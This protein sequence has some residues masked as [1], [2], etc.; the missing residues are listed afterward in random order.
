MSSDDETT[1]T[2]AAATDAFLYFQDADGLVHTSRLDALCHAL[3][4]SAP[5]ASDWSRMHVQRQSADARTGRITLDEF[6]SIIQYTETYGINDSSDDSDKEE[7]AMTPQSILDTV[8]RIASRDVSSE[9]IEQLVSDTATVSS[10]LGEYP[11]PPIGIDAYTVRANAAAPES[12]AAAAR[13]FRSMGL[14]VVK[15]LLPAD[16]V[17]RAYTQA[18]SSLQKLLAAIEARGAEFG[19]GTQRGFAEVVRRTPARYEM[20]HEMR[21]GVF[22]ESSVRSNQWL[23]QLI[24]LT[25]M[26]GAGIT[27]VA[28]V[29]AGAATAA[30]ATP[31]TQTRAAYR[32][33]LLISLPGAGVQEWHMDGGHIEGKIGT[34]STML[35]A[36]AVNVFVALTDITLEM[37]PTELYPASHFLTRRMAK[38]VLLAKVQQTL[39]APVRPTLRA[40]DALVFDYRVLHRGTA[41]D[42]ERPR[43][44]LELVYTREGWCDKINF[45]VRSVFS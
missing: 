23:A 22:A 12:V 38:S 33:S 24:P 13:C 2:H 40:G 6:L 3:G 21:D 5:S 42:S 10:E 25:M 32:H 45:P 18:T 29:T 1:W 35:P 41:N 31:T 28:P 16:T 30:A 39:H 14:V 37:G 36:H 44:M 4:A 19:V 26:R 8:E 9:D 34:T 17:A 7:G 20:N 11:L 27:A 43:A 15:E